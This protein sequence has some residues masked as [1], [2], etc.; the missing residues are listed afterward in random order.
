MSRQDSGFHVGYETAKSYQAEMREVRA[1]DRTARQIRVAQP[2]GP[3]LHLIAHP[4][5]RLWAVIQ[6]R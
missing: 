4:R 1:R 2:D 6:R 5:R 3:N